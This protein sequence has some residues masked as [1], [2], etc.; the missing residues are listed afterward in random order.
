MDDLFEGGKLE[1]NFM[2]GF[3]DGYLVGRGGGER[4]CRAFDAEESKV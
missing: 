1:I 3:V 2:K 4:D